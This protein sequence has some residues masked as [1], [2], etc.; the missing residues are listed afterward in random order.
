MG[1]DGREGKG[2]TREVWGVFPENKGRGAG[3]IQGKGEEGRGLW[4]LMREG[5]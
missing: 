3:L 2:C 4:I 1:G 5:Y